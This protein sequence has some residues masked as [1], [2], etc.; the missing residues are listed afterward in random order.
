M[1]HHD[2]L[3]TGG[4]G[5]I[6]SHLAERLLAE[7]ARVA[8]ID[9]LSTGSIRNLDGLIGRE[10]FSYHIDTILNRPL[11]AE[12]VDRAD[13]V[14]HLAAAVGVRLIVEHPVETIETNI[15]GTEAVLELVARKGKRTFIA[16]SSEIYGKSQ[17]TPFSEDD[18][19]VLGPTTM[20]RWCYACSKAI[21]EF[22]ALAYHAERGL[23]VVI[24]R[25][26]NTVGPRQT[27]RY[28]MVL[29]RFVE[30]ALAGRPI[31]VYGDG[32]QTRTFVHV[33]DTVRASIALMADESITGDI[34]NI[35]SDEEVTI[36]ELA[37]RVAERAGTGS[38]VV[39][40][41]YDQAYA[42]GFEDLQR[43]APSIE[44]LRRRA[45]FSPRYNLD[46]IIDSVIE[47]QRMNKEG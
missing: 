18:D 9:N 1:K 6:G 30:A 39:H 10:G 20:S 41:P 2:V 17:K 14:F 47:Y 44:R 29:P 31:E 35:G 19:M 23:P 21:D 12:L 13:W 3:I 27:G 22:L 26:F 8:V 24:G 37:R 16:S 43:R 33:D 40:I 5:F 11:L 38:R 36:N 45:G 7:G 25:F 15:K 46:Q 4:A 42:P 28:G 34:F 32:E